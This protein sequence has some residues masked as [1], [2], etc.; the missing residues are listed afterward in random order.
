VLQRW[1]PDKNAKAPA[2]DPTVLDPWVENDAVRGAT[3]C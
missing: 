2:I 1:L 3:Y